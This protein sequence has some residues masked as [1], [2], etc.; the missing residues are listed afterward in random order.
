MICEFLMHGQ[1]QIGDYPIEVRGGQV[2]PRRGG[3]NLWGL[4]APR[5]GTGKG[6]LTFWDCLSSIPISEYICYE[7]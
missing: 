1:M 2:G 5:E 7:I 3:P 4:V 6:G